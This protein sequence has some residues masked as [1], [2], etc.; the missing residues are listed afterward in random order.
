LNTITVPLNDTGTGG[1]A[2]FYVNLPIFFTGNVFGGIVENLTYYVTT[3]IDSQ[4]FTMSENQD[5][6]SVTV[7]SATASTNIINCESTLD[8]NI[9][10]PVIFN[11]MLIAGS[12]VTDYG[13][14]QDGTTYYV[15]SILNPSQLTI[16][17][18]VNGGTFDITSDVVAASNT[19]ALMTSQA[20]TVTLTTATG[21]MTMN[22]SLPVSPGQVNGQLFTL[23]PTSEQYNSV[24]GTDGSL[25]TRTIEKT[26]TGV[27]IIAITETSGGLTNLYDN[28]PIEVETNIGGLTTGTQYY[29]IDYGNISVTVTNTSSTGNALLCTSTASLYVDMPIIFSGTGLGTIDLS[30]EY[31]VKSIPTSTTFTVTNTPGG[32]ETVMSNDNG[33]MVGTGSPYIQVS[34]T[35]G[36]TAETLSTA[37]GPVTLTQTPIGTPSFDAS[38]ILG[39]YRVVIEDGATGYAVD[40]VITISGNQIGGSSTAN[41]LTLTV[42]SVSSTGAITSV[43][44]SGTPAGTSVQYYFRVL[45][46][47]QFGVYSNSVNFSSITSALR[48]SLLFVL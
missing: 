37:T 1:T 17:S 9:N 29:I 12:A 45:S 23:Y 38:Y 43:I 11:N 39:G 33:T 32:A 16:S 47:N 14:I 4:T 40:N 28:M 8:L 26:L 30:V 21:N 2:G 41:D 18:V 6:V 3:V 13:G 44:C 5:S 34:Q 48:E 27:D 36:G 10:D 7:Y 25:I 24:T 35:L 46:A 19:S 15:S 20:D 31:Y 42:D 22:V